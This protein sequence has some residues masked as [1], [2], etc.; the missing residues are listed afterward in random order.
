MDTAND[1]D[2]GKNGDGVDAVTGTEDGSKD[3]ENR[4][5]CVMAGAGTEEGS[6]GS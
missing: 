3:V 6:E 2:V 4:E 5:D 1:G